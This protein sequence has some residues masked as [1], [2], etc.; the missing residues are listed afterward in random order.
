M[1][2]HSL[3]PPTLPLK[4]EKQTARVGG[5]GLLFYNLRAVLKER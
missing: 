4:A 1:A 3:Y 5:R 2:V